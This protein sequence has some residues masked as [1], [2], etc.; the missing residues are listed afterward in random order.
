MHHASGVGLPPSHLEPKSV[1]LAGPGRFWPFLFAL[2][3]QLRQI[4]A[5]IANLSKNDNS[6]KNG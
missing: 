1:I 5:T 4:T 2:N 6:H 3:E